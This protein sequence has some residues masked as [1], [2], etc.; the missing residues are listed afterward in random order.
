VEAGKLSESLVSRLSLSRSGKFE[1]MLSGIDEVAELP[2]PTGK[3]TYAKELDEGLE[4]YRVTCPIGV[5]LV[6]FEARPEVVV[7]IA[8]LAIK[9]GNAAI[10]KGGKESVHTATLLS[11]LIQK[12]LATTEFPSTLIQSVATRSEISSLLAQDKY[13]DLVMPRGGNALVTSVKDQT[14]IPVMGH[15][16]GICSIYVDEKVD[17]RMV[18]RIVLDSKVSLIG[19]YTGNAILIA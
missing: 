5:L 8:A 16:D 19:M 6:I 12:A 17:E 1:A 15:A 3:T 9:S 10:L 2:I 13:I 4:L 14:K 18:E 7:N 11:N